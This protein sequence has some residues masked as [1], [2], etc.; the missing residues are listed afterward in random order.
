MLSTLYSYLFFAYHLYHWIIIVDIHNRA[1]FLSIQ[2]H[3]PQHNATKDSSLQN[4]MLP[5]YCLLACYK[6]RM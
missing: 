3:N 4:Q 5:L 1:Q 2:Y 6:P